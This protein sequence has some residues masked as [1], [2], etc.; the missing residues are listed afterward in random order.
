[1]IGE[2]NY[3]IEFA[4]NFYSKRKTAVRRPS[5]EPP[6]AKILRLSRPCLRQG[7]QIG[8][9]Q[10]VLLPRYVPPCMKQSVSDIPPSM[11][12]PSRQQSA[13]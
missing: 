10:V 8:S 7:E 3:P 2:T 9:V 13:D 4:D 6:S 12:D 11:Y 5:G 1:M